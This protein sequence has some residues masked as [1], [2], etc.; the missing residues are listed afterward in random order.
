MHRKLWI[1]AAFITLL[2]FA[3]RP[4]ALSAA[5]TADAIRLYALNGGYIEMPD[6]GFFSDTGEGAGKPGRVVASSF[7]I[8][9]PKGDL[10]W[11]TG[12]GDALAAKPEGVSPAPGFR[13]TV[14]IKLVDQLQAAG[15][16][17]ADIDYLA[18]SHMHADHTGNANLFT[19]ASW[20]LVQR[21]LDYATTTPAPQGVDPTTFS[22]YKSVAKQFVNG[23]QDVFG[24]GKVRIL[25]APGHT[26]GHQVLA[27]TLSKA[28][29]IVLSG[30]L[31]HTKLNA[32]L[33]LVPPFNYSRAD[34]L[35]SFDR[36][37]RILKN[38]K[39]R[40]IVQHAEE[41]FATLPKPPQFMQ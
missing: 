36:I 19:K 12:L 13:N 27:V 28:G 18:F 20:F 34:T 8:R 38:T 29:T 21:E 16:T 4:L 11:D 31:W 30:D 15:V 2:G 6:M 40:L 5:E 22:A 35:A 26:P 41:D 32:K 7:L 17:P 1:T 23:D 14:P 24:D 9:H 37:D 33:K 39:G 25:K 10:L 3:L